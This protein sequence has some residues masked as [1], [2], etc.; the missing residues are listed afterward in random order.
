MRGLDR[1][2]LFL[3]AALFAVGPAMAIQ[4]LTHAEEA[5]ARELTLRE[6][7]A[8]DPT[9]REAWRVPLFALV[10]LLGLAGSVRALDVARRRRMR[11]VAGR[12]LGLLVGGMTLLDATYL[13]DTRWLFGVP[14]TVRA[15]FVLALYPLAAALMAGSAWRLGELED[16]FGSDAPRRGILEAE[17]RAGP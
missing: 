3:S 14:Y 6:E 8:L 5:R 10:V 2:L 4:E 15:A 17:R 16:A 1:V 7:V 9:F 12:L 11:A 13:L